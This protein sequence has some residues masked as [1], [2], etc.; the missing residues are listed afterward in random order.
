MDNLPTTARDTDAHTE[1]Q[2]VAVAALDGTP[3]ENPKHEQFARLTLSYSA[4][5]AFRRAFSESTRA[6]PSTIWES[7]CRLAARADIKRRIAEL[8][9]LAARESAIEV[10]Q[11]A[12]E[13]HETIQAD[14]SELIC[15]GACRY[16]HG[17]GH[18]YQHIDE[19]EFLAEAVAALEAA[20]SP[21]HDDAGGYGYN[22][23][24]RPVEDC[25]RCFGSG[26]HW[27]VTDFSK[28]STAA[29]RLVKGVGKHGELLLVDPMVAR[30]QLHRILGAYVDRSENVNLNA[31]V[32][33]P[34]SV[35]PA[36]VLDLW[37]S[38]RGDTR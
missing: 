8:R 6:K 3:L 18:R 12:R 20:R 21:E 32:A 17:D 25:P 37:R 9:A 31:T 14:I 7:A 36:D 30:D 4:S 24:L 29:R 13:L 26:D 15:R 35:T 27:H 28:A 34:P 38:S 22:G 10:G 5:E 1:T 19:R 33:A 2:G 11:L 16:C 23:S